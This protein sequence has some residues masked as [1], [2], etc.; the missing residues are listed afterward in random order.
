MGFYQYLKQ[1]WKKPKQ[2]LGD[3]WKERL[4]EWRRQGSFVKLDK[5]TR[6]DKARGLGYRAKQGI[7]II[8]S[9]VPRGGKKR[10]TIGRRGRRPKRFGHRLVLSKNYQRVAEERTAK[11]YK[12]L[13]V[14]NSY[15]VIKDGNY[16]W[17]EVIMIDWAH[18][19]IRKDKKLKWIINK[20]GRAFKGLTSS[21]RKS[22][23]LKHKGKG[24]EKLRPSRYSHIKRKLAKK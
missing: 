9:R 14:L 7:I 6:L 11:K 18:P 3:A 17:F 10:S 23:G 22:R 24:A 13:E 16:I 5:P 19:V 8:R 21:G 2:G 12:N 15:Y 4:I 1:M 20:P